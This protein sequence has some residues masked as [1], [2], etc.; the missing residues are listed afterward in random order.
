N[1]IVV[2]SHVKS[3]S[4]WSRRLSQQCH[5]VCIS[6]CRRFKRCC[7]NAT[8]MQESQRRTVP[9]SAVSGL[10]FRN[11]GNTAVMQESPRRT[12]PRSAVSGCRNGGD[13]GVM[14][15]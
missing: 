2:H 10:D 7:G 11:G 5:V 15:E 12:V 14:V 8:V 9:R 1:R 3:N 13:A 4:D 6:D